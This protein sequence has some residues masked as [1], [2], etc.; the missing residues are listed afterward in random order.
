MICNP[1]LEMKNEQDELR[2]RFP[3]ASASFLKRNT[4][5]AAGNLSSDPKSQQIVCDDPL[6][7][8]PGETKNSGRVSV[9]IVSYR[10]RLLDPDN[11]IGGA[12]YFTDTLRYCGLIPD[13]REQ[14]I[15]L[16]VEQK[17]SNQECTLI[18]ILK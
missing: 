2:K 14:D 1:L 17:K 7:K 3:H 8:T 15:T 13:D 12:K 4:L 18:E 11:L 9:R 10:K 5:P 6:A 16:Q